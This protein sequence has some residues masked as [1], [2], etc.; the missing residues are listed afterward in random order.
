MCA[1]WFSQGLLPLICNKIKKIYLFV[2]DVGYSIT[3]CTNVY[4]TNHEGVITSPNYPDK[5]PDFTS[6]SW[7]IDIPKNSTLSIRYVY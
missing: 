5:Y 6:C 2:S 1:I 7:Y 4:I 3:D